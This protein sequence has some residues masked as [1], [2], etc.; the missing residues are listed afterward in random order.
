MAIT[1]FVMPKLAMGMNEGTVNEWLVSDG[2]KVEKGDHI[3]SI[4]TEKVAYDLEAPQAGYFK[5]IGKVGETV[6]CETVIAAFVNTE[7]ELAF[8]D[9]ASLGSAP[10]ADN[11][12]SFSAAAEAVAAPAPSAAPAAPV[13]APATP[14]SA[15]I[16]IAAFNT[17]RIIAS[18]LARKMAANKGLELA[19]IEG[20][21]PGSR[22]VKRDIEKAEQTGAGRAPAAVAGMLQG[23]VEQARIPMSG[24]RRAISNAMMEKTNGTATLTQ[25]NEVDVTDLLA[26]RKHLAAQEDL[27]GTK[28]SVNAFF[29]KAIA[30]AAKQ[31]PI[32]NSSLQGNDIVVWDNVNVAVALALPSGDSYTENLMVPV[33]KNVDRL[34]LVEIDAEMKRLINLGREGRLG[35]AEMADSTIT[36]STT[37][38]IAPNG[39]SG[40]S[41][42]NGTNNAIVGI[43][44]A[45]K[46][47]AEHNGEIALRDLAP[48]CVNYDHQVID[49]APA[50]RYMN[51]LYL[52]LEDPTLLLT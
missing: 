38:G 29:I 28:V 27:L 46:K 44:G 41:I 30:W 19:Y 23:L 51:Y 24:M 49:G 35:A 15:P 32:V 1:E 47:P 11:P 34:S 10:A 13:S 37:A 18:P 5:I 48:V 12:S 17:G 16:N 43:G 3:A 26:A 21:G 33:I 7:E 8:I 39:T 20:T 6:P 25:F 52:A 22:I 2:Q 31:V 36:F 40:N 14:A 42:L 50:S 4:E 9:V 45:K